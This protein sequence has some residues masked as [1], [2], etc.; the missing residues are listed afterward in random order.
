VIERAVVSH[1]R[2]SVGRLPQIA[3]TNDYYR[4]LALA[5]RDRL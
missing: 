1:L 5:V 4:A 3:N 2:Y